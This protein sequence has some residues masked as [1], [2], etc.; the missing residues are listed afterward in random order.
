[1]SE[2]ASKLPAEPP[3]KEPNTVNLNLR[4]PTGKVVKRRFL[5]SNPLSVVET[6][7][8]IELN[9]VNDLKLICN[10]PRKDFKDMKALIGTAFDSDTT[11]IVAKA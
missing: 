8:K 2:L 11:V 3:E 9:Q 7:C 10:Y 1:M 6:F 4:L 5:K